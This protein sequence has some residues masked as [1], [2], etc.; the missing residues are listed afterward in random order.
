MA[1]AASDFD[2]LATR[3]EI[4]ADAFEIVGVKRAGQN[5]TA[6]QL[7]QG[8][9]TLQKLVKSWSNK[10]IFLWSFA[11]SSF[12]TS[13]NQPH[14]T[15]ANGLAGLD[16][17][18]AIGLDK[19][20]VV[21]DSIE[22]EVPLEVISYSHYLDISNKPQTGRPMFIAYQPSWDLSDSSLLAE[23]HS[24]FYLWPTPDDN[25]G[26]DYEINVLCLFPLK[27]F[28]TADGYGNVPARFQR[29]LTYGLAEDLFDK[30]PGPMNE[31]EFVASKAAQL[32]R[33]AKLSDV[34]PETTNEVESL[35]GRSK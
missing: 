15:N 3:N 23:K 20:S 11:K 8:V 29:A 10:H 12:T 5:L 18:Q 27:D 28:D 35:F 22:T 21:V 9:T 26:S 1:W 2:Y 19:A 7:Q 6:A 13:N 34:T 32:F 24:G 31:R 17:S 33:E 25:G 4:I 16:L 30:Y 14:Y